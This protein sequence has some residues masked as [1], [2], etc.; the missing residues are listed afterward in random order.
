[1]VVGV[2]TLTVTETDSLL[3][4]ITAEAGTWHKKRNGV[5]NFTIAIMMLDAG[6][7]VGEVI[8]LTRA[9]LYILGKPVATLLVR[10]IVAKNGT[11]RTVPLGI[12]VR[13]ALCCHRQNWLNQATFLN[14]EYVFHINDRYKHISTRQVERILR[15]ASLASIG[16]PIHPHV[17]RHTCATRLMRVSDIRTV[18]QLLGHKNLSSTQIYTH[19]DIEDMKAAVNRLDDVGTTSNPLANSALAGTGVPKNTDAPSADRNM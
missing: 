10:G 2:K 8:Q 5:R 12:R 1:M 15:K 9:D 6:L 19:P 14:D 18:Q 16:R 7:R 3:T 4:W 13:A 11:E 17:L